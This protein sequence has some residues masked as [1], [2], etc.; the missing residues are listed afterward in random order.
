MNYTVYDL[1]LSTRGSSLKLVELGTC[2]T[3][4]RRMQMPR[5]IG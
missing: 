4:V 2:H 5:A 1:F 3:N